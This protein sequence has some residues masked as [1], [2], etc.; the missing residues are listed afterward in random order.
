VRRDFLNDVLHHWNIENA[1]IIDVESTH[2]QNAA[3]QIAQT[4]GSK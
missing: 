1:I 2:V 4:I 3:E